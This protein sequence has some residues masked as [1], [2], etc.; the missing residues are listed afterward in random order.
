[1]RDETHE[2]ALPKLLL[3]SFIQI[4]NSE[5]RLVFRVDYCLVKLTNLQ[6]LFMKAS[7]ISAFQINTISHSFFYKWWIISLTKAG[8]YICN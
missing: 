5:A 1:M 8:S 6:I 4:F 2:I 7:I 3:L